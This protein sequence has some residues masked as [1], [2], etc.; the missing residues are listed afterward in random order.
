M[1]LFGEKRHVQKDRNQPSLRQRCFDLFQQGQ[2]PSQVYKIVPVSL[3]TACRY[4]EDFKKL[5]HRVPYSTVRRWL[6]E[7]PAFSSK[8]VNLLATSLDMTPAEALSRLEK[9]WGLYGALKGDWPNYRLD[10]ERTELEVRL[11]AALEVIKFAEV[12]G[13]KDPEFVRVSLR[14][15]ILQRAEDSSE[16]GPK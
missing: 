8:T 16:T 3:R 15:L 6:R 5:Y 2:R 12:F 14:N 11:L 10:R 1:R 4:F 7:N 9:P 13:R